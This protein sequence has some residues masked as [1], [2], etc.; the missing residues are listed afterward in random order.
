M[1]RNIFMTAA[2]L[3]LLEPFSHAKPPLKVIVA[4]DA[5]LEGPGK[6]VDSAGGD[7]VAYATQF[8]YCAR[9]V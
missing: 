2:L 8:L 5:A 1:K 3:C 4:M 6:M 7:T 9:P